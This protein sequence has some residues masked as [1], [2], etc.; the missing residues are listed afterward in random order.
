MYLRSTMCL[1]ALLGGSHFIGF[2]STAQAQD[3]NS[4]VWAPYTDRFGLIH[5]E[6]V[7]PTTRDPKT[8]NGLL[9]TAEA[10]AI[11]QLSHVSY[12]RAKFREA[13]KASEVMPGLYNR[14]PINHNDEEAQDDYVGLGAFAG[15]CGFPDVAKDILNYGSAN[16]GVSGTAL[17]LPSIDD[18]A[19]LPK[20]I[21]QCGGVSYNYNNISPGKF[22]QATWMGRYPAMITQWKM[23]AGLRPTQADFGVWSAVLVSSG[24]SASTDQDHWLLSWLMILTYEMSPYH[25]TVA[26]FAVG[27]WWGMLH[28]RYPA[29]IKRTM[30]DYLGSGASGNPLAIYIDDFESTRNPAAT[31]V[32]TDITSKDLLSQ[33]QGTLTMSC[34]NTLPGAVCVDYSNFAPGNL[35]AP[36]TMALSGASN[37]LST[38]STAVAVQQ[39]LADAQQTAVNSASQ[40]INNLNTQ[41]GSLQ[42][43][44]TALMQ[45]SV[46]LLQQKSDMIAHG[47]DKLPLPGHWVTGCAVK[48]FGVCT[49][50]IPP[51]FVPGGF[52]S[53]PNFEAI[54]HSA[55]D[56]AN[57]V[58]ALQRSIDQAQANLVAA[59]SDLTQR[60]ATLATLKAP[61]AGLQND[62][63][64][65]KGEVDLTKG[66]LQYVQAVVQNLN[67][68]LNAPPGYR[69]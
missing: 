36:F 9:Y 3:F 5:S 12:D 48:V 1:F 8:N 68:C 11:M 15:V 34:G 56:T 16:N 22:S 32:D 7:D 69:P 60:I 20:T 66:K 41:I 52:G 29:G 51:V 61:L 26:D 55:T 6:P 40:L 49:V 64:K 25:S 33:I 44:H 13:I 35:L 57:Q 39:A 21:Q 50:P 23:A 19:A 14:S 59:Q 37:A 38:A 17:I 30:T 10:C 24:Q 2:G 18:F 46:N 54:S 45:Q 4:S 58:L 63:T 28:A 31:N 65:A 67:P 62:I 47:L 42:T 53:N 27:E 43:Q